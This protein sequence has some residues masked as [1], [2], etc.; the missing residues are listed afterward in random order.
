MKVEATSAG[1]YDSPAR[2]N[3][4]KL[5]LLTIEGLLSSTERAELPDLSMG[6]HTFKKAKVEKR[7]TGEQ[8]GLF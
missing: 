1:F 5:Q 7:P 3:V 2:G 4:P 6:A 8:E